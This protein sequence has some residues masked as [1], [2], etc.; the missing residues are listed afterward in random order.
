[1]NTIAQHVVWMAQKVRAAIDTNDEYE[2]DVEVGNV[3]DVLSHDGRFGLYI[4]PPGPDHDQADYDR[5]I[6]QCVLYF[7]EMVDNIADDMGAM[8]EYKHK[9]GQA[10]QQSK[11]I[12]STFAGDECKGIK[13]EMKIGSTGETLRLCA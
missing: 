3:A 4:C 6:D 11:Y 7:I 9:L 13:V 5:V 1:M 12:L 10:R 8:I 2:G